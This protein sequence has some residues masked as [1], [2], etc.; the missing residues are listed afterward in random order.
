MV[1]FLTTV[2][3]YT[4]GND[5]LERHVSNLSYHLSSGTL[6]ST[7]LLSGHSVLSVHNFEH[8]DDRYTNSMIWYKTDAVRYTNVQSPTF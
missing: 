8:D 7:H 1:I 5:C 4:S 6:Y 2:C 3:Q